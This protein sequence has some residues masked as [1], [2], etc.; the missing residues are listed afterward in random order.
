MTSMQSTACI[1]ATPPCCYCNAASTLRAP[2]TCTC[3]SALASESP[4]CVLSN[5]IDPAC[6]HFNNKDFSISSNMR[7][8][9]PFLRPL[10][11]SLSPIRKSSCSWCRS[12]AMPL[13]SSFQDQISSHERTSTPARPASVSNFRCSVL[14][15]AC[16]EYATGFNY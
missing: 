4:F 15:R 10:V 9:I 13:W 14:V 2:V 7:A 3:S 12:P 5:T 1:I 6:V 16:I 8:D 11:S